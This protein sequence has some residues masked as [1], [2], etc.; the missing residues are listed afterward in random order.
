MDNN[1]K[2]HR[3]LIQYVSKLTT[4]QINEFLESSNDIPYTSFTDIHILNMVDIVLNSDVDKYNF[5][6]QIHNIEFIT[7]KKIA[8]IY[9]LMGNREQK[10]N[11]ILSEC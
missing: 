2:L 8:T 10:I 6:V 4:K 1:T 7:Y 5:G 11:R 3:K 9:F